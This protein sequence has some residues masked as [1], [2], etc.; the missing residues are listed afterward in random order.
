MSYRQTRDKALPPQSILP[1]NDITISPQKL[2]NFIST[3]FD[4]I[5]TFYDY[6]SYN[7]KLLT[8]IKKEFLQLFKK[9][10]LWNVQVL[11]HKT[12]MHVFK[13]KSKR[14]GQ[15][16]N[17]R[18]DISDKNN[19]YCSEHIGKKHNDNIKKRNFSAEKR[20]IFIKKNGKQCEL[21]FKKN[22][23]CNYHFSE[24][25]VKDLEEQNNLLSSKLFKQE[26]HNIVKGFFDTKSLYN[27]ID[28]IKNNNLN[29]DKILFKKY[30]NKEII[31]KKNEQSS[32]Y[33]YS[34]ISDKIREIDK[35]VI[36][37]NN[38]ILLNNSKFKSITEYINILVEKNNKIN[39]IYNIYKDE[40]KNI[41]DPVVMF[42]T[43]CGI[44]SNIYLLLKEN[45]FSNLEDLKKFINTYKNHK[46]INI[47]FYDEKNGKKINLEKLKNKYKE[48]EKM[49][50]YIYFNKKYLYIEKNNKNRKFYYSE[51]D[52]RDLLEEI[53]LLYELMYDACIDKEKMY[54]YKEEIDKAIVSFYNIDDKY[55]LYL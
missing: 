9:T 31:E 39:T 3:S 51:N 1:K 6:D 49:E 19:Y 13:D 54:S 15:I 5:T 25:R 42:E 23:F 12:C 11:S 16:C 33:S 48:L 26:I 28:N 7:T 40:Y 29:N 45:N 55:K 53:Q 47:N 2:Y 50:R 35:N 44:Q 34:N 38:K 14:F 8:S 52:I 10:F 21:P 37:F 18:I 43:V 4:S 20:C 27:I 22:K 32:I 24:E 36:E 30:Y 46:C 17:K 41:N